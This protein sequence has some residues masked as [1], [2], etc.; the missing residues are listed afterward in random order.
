MST[1]ETGDTGIDMEAAVDSISADLNLGAIETEEIE[2]ELPAETEETSG[3]IAAAED[4]PA[5]ESDT[6]TAAVAA[7]KQ[8]TVRPVPKSWAKEQHERWA[9]IDPQTQEYIELR[10]KQML[11]GIEQYKGDAGFGKTL[12]EVMAPYK[13]M[14]AA[15]GV[16]EPK[17][18]QYLLNAHYKLTTAPAHEKKAYF[19]SLAKSYGIEL[20]QSTEQPAQVD[21][22]VKSLQDKVN[23]LESSL[24]AREQAVLHETRTKTAQEVEAFAADPKH[25]YFDE[26]ADDIVA[27]IKTGLPLQD[28]YEKA[29]WANPITRAKEM[30]RIQTENEAKLRDKSKQEA[31]IAKKASSTNVRSRDT[32]RAPTEPLGT[33]EDTMK[34]TLSEIRSR[35]H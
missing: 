34:A 12:R 30:A 27:L 14:L 2:N 28:A 4:K 22:I 16:D 26:V 35:T 33:M 32:K 25:A 7:D 31:I 21:P 19:E 10:E 15:Q 18:V 23:Q 11:D 3:P 6:Q 8:S 20:V 5:G 1:E 29:V 24:T 13:P 17:A 9:K